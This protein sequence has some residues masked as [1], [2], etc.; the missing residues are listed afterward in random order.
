MKIS[1]ACGCTDRTI[2]KYL[3]ELRNYG[4][5]SWVQRGLNQ[6]NIYFIN[7]L[8]KV[9]RLKSLKDKDRKECSGQERKELSDK[10][11]SVENNNNNN[12]V[13]V[14]DPA[15][16]LDD[17]NKPTIETVSSTARD[18]SAVFSL[19]VNSRKGAWE[20]IREKVREVAG[21]DIYV[22]FAQEI[23]HKY[24]KEKVDAIIEVLGRQL[25]AGVEIRGVGAWLRAA[26]ERGF[27]PDQPAAKVIPKPER[28]VPY[29][30]RA[31]PPKPETSYQRTPESVDPA[32]LKNELLLVLSRLS[33]MTSS[34]KLQYR[35]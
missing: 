6:T 15:L 31:R 32:A 14:F 34:S 12:N 5:I 9:G 26:L 22:S 20:E 29:R 21:A 24:P 10:E 30:G 3:D 8:S 1:E 33:G 23:A 27:K 17:E 25:R 18:S 11:Y 4:L 28:K 7:E 19:L 35:Q 13:V 16:G 2:R